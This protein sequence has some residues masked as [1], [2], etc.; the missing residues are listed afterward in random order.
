M[1]IGRC[2]GLSRW[3]LSRLSYRLCCLVESDLNLKTAEA[4]SK[5][6]DRKLGALILEE[7]NLK[8]ALGKATAE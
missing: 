1:R 5:E 4:K 6:S 8:G 7:I 2:T 3:L